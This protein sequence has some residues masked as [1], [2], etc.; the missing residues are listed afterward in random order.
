MQCV[1]YESFWRNVAAFVCH[2]VLLKRWLR[3]NNLIPGLVSVVLLF[4]GFCCLELFMAR[5]SA[6]NLWLTAPSPSG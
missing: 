6:R 2:S 5:Q 4:S 1:F 3:Q